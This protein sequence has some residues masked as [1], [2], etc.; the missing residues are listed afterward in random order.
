ME[1]KTIRN[2]R[3]CWYNHDGNTNITVLLLVIDRCN[4]KNTTKKIEDE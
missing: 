3:R 1:I 2:T 4:K